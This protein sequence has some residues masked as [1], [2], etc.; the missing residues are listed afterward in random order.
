M[1]NMWW[2]K[3]LTTLSLHPF[4]SNLAVLPTRGDVFFS[5]HGTCFGQKDFGRSNSNQSLNHIPN[6]LPLP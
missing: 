5:L 1:E 3:L 2:I 4:I 6:V